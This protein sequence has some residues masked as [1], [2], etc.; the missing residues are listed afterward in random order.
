METAIIGS[1]LAVV[2]GSVTSAWLAV[3]RRVARLGEQHAG[4]AALV[5]E[6]EKSDESRFQRIDA[7]LDKL[8]GKLDRL[9][10]RELS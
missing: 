4:L 9:I 7:G 3:G 2:L 8:D 1:C 6:H 10:E 5:V